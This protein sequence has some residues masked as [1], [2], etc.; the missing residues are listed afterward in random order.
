MEKLPPT[1][2]IRMV[3]VWLIVC[4]ML[5]FLQV[6][7]LTI[8]EAVA[9]DT[10]V[11]NHHGF[12]RETEDKKKAWEEKKVVFGVSVEQLDRTMEH[13]GKLQVMEQRH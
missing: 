7:I 11:I 13:L 1:S 2:Y 8:R 9:D 4:Q 10:A 3:D 12:G 6:A 5:P